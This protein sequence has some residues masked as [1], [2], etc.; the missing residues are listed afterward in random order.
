MVEPIQ[1]IKNCRD[2]L[3]KIF[4]YIEDNEP[5]MM[6]GPEFEEMYDVITMLDIMGNYPIERCDD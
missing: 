4:N 2:K 6:Y 3:V 5:E 1:E